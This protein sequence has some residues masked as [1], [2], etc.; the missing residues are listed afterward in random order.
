MNFNLRECSP[1][2]LHIVR[3]FVSLHSIFVF[4]FHRLWV[5]V[6]K[7]LVVYALLFCC[8]SNTAQISE[9]W[10]K[11]SKAKDL[12]HTLTQTQN[13]QK[14]MSWEH[15]KFC[16]LLHIG[17]IK[18]YSV[19]VLCITCMSWRRHKQQQQQQ[20]KQHTYAFVT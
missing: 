13:S 8:K 11:D 1:H 7:F 20:Q 12:K 18:C 9:T 4:L 3:V 19:S 10:K 2:N 5:F 15:G 16:M 6:R 14:P 17:T